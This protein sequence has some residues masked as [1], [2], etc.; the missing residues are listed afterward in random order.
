MTTEAS[1]M[2]RPDRTFGSSGDVHFQ[3]RQTTSFDV[4]TPHHRKDIWEGFLGRQWSCRSQ[5]GAKI[6]ASISAHQAA[7]NHCNG[8]CR[9]PSHRAQSTAQQK[10]RAHRPA[11]SF[12]IAYDLCHHRPASPFIG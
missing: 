1:V 8:R 12:Q 7:E 3:R 5:I 6:G 4:G 2:K 10:G 11:F 9:A